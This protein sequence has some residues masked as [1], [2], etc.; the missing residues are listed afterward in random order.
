MLITRA[1]HASGELLR[2]ADSGRPQQWQ[3][4]LLVLPRDRE[5]RDRPRGHL[6]PGESG[7]VVT[8]F[9]YEELCI[10]NKQQCQIF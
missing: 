8:T 9:Q 7:E 1:D 4:V 5:P 2:A 10:T 3:H 6:A